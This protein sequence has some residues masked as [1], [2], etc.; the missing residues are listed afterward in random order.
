MATLERAQELR[1]SGNSYREIAEIL[2]R[3]G[4]VSRRGTPF[5][6]TGIRNLLTESEMARE[7]A[8]AGM[9]GV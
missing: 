2:K 1:S 3:E 8:L 9:N 6:Y 4:V 7:R 5:A